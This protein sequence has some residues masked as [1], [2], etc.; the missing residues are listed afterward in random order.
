M[1]WQYLPSGALVA[2]MSDGVLVL[3]AQNRVADINPAACRLLGL[4]Q[5]SIL[6]QPVCALLPGLVAQDQAATEARLE[7][8]L[9][10]T[11]PRYVDAQISPLPDQHGQRGG[12]LNAPDVVDPPSRRPR[13]SP[14][15]ECKR[16]ADNGCT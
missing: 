16:C 15:P 10:Q 11:P 7:L 9:A 3:D 8:R 1:S 12:R 4:D 13:R 14:P 5:D 2:S 6:G